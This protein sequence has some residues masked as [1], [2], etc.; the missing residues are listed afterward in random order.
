MKYIQGTSTWYLI[1]T[2]SEITPNHVDFNYCLQIGGRYCTS[3]FPTALLV[4]DTGVATP[5][6]SMTD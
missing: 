5:C 4:H 3:V 1:H 6:K 2:Y